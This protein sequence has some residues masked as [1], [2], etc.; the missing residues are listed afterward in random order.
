MLTRQINKYVACSISF[1]F[2]LSASS[3]SAASVSLYGAVDSNLQWSEKKFSLHGENYKES[4]VG[5]DDGYIKS[6]VWGLKGSEEINP[7]LEVFFNL[8]SKFSLS[9]GTSK[10]MFN[11]KSFLGLRH[12]A[13][14]TLS[15]GK[16]KSSSDDF[17]PINTVRGLG[18]ISRAFGASGV[19]AD[20]LLKYESPEI[21]GLSLGVSY[22]RK[23]SVVRS[24]I[25]Q[26]ETDFEHYS[27]FAAHYERGPWQISASYDRKR[28]LDDN[29]HSENFS[30]RGWVISTVYDFDLLELSLAY[31]RDYNG[32]FNTAGAIKSLEGI[33]P[34]IAGEQLI[35]FYNRPGFKSKNYYV[36]VS[37]PIN[38][39]KWGVSWARSSSNMGSLFFN[40]T[41][42]SL[43]TGKQDIFATQLTYPLSKRTTIYA[44]GAYGKNLAY[45]DKLTAKEFGVGLSHRF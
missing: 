20:N 22:A 26:Q 3:I 16:Q 42:H 39:W 14:G 29:K 13:W 35:G 15:L 41:G 32:K 11:K 7:Q 1:L 4:R 24:D 25:H 37:V 12:D 18:K 8:E 19:T 9:D 36:G 28:G 45:L 27:S 30:L 40:E 21:A 33:Q 31:G 10:D 34:E 6:N 2:L 23:G 5:L 38:Q 17:L 44:Y 43:S